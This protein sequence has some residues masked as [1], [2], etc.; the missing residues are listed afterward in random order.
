MRDP[1]RLITSGCSCTQYCWP[2]WADYLGLHFEN[3]VNVGLCGA[4]NAVVARNVMEIARPGDF[5][6][7]AWTSFDR[8]NT[9]E[10][11]R[12]QETKTIGDKLVME[13]SMLDA[14][15]QG[16]WF[17]SGGRCGSKEF[18]VNHYNAIE[19]F[20]HSLDY[21][22]MLEMHSQ[23]IGYTLYN[24]SMIEWFLGECEKTI[25]QRLVGMHNRTS[26][27]HFY[28]GK[29]LLTLRKEIL[30]LCPKH[31]YNPWGDTHPTPWV[32]WT[33]LKHY[34]AAEI[35]I[36]IDLEIEKKVVIDQQRVLEGD[37][38]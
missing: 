27:N 3:F 2:T 14:T 38:D 18:L 30:P 34:I 19:R 25:D 12:I 31:K 6:V 4:D 9:F 21:V 17:H 16:G 10:N 7:V 32:N 29:D 13:W 33:W 26:L 11:S 28:L 24:F 23:L 5:V 35:G 15:D 1:R 8:F 20:R 37:V 22:K 36:E